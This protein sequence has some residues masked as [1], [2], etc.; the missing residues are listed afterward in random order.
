MRTI[1]SL[2]VVGLLGIVLFGSDLLFA[3]AVGGPN[4][5]A[6]ARLS[7]P[8]RG[9]YSV[10]PAQRWEEALVSGNGT[11]GVL[12]WGQPREERII[13]NHEALYEPLTNEPCQVPNIAEAFPKVRELVVQGKYK[14]AY[15]YSIKSAADKGYSGPQPTD[16]YHPAMAMLIRQPGQGQLDGYMRSV[17]FT[18]GEIT[19]AWSDANDLYTRRTFVS[20][21]DNVVVLLIESPSG[22]KINASITLA[23]QDTRSTDGQGGY[24]EP[25]IKS[26]PDWIGYR[27]KYTHTKRGYECLVRVIRKGGTAQAN[28]GAVQIQDAN[29][30]LLLTRIVPLEDFSASQLD[31]TQKELA[32]LPA[33]YQTLLKPHAKVHGDMFSRMSLDLSGGL[34]RRVSTEELLRM[35]KEDSPSTVLPAYLEK[36]FD[37]GRYVFISASGQRPPN[38]TGIWN[39]QWRPA[40]S[41]GFILDGDLN[42]QMAGANIGNMCEGTK[43]YTNLITALLPDWRT[44]AKNLFGCRGLVSGTQTD[45]RHGLQTQFSDTF[46][47]QFWTAG[48]E[49]LIAPMYEYYQVTGDREYLTKTLLPIMKEI[50]QFYSDFLTITTQEGQYMFAP[51]YSPENSPSNTHCPAAVNADMDLACAREVLTN[52]VTVCDALKIEQPN[53]AKWQAMLMK[54]PPYRID[55]DG[56]LKEWAWPWLEDNADHRHNSLFY[57]VW[58]G[59]EINP[60]D[61]P[62]MFNAAKIAARKRGRESDSGYGLADMA[63]IGARLKDADIVSKNLLFMLEGDYVLP[64][65]FTYGSPGQGYNADI[66]CSLPAIVIEMLVYSRPGVVELLPA[67][68]DSMRIGQIKGVL[69]RGQI[70]ITSLE[71]NLVRKHVAVTM[72]SKKDQ[73]ISLILRRGMAAIAGPGGS[74]FV[75]DNPQRAT[76]ELK[77]DKPQTISIILP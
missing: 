50:A 22:G 62:G 70:A 72:V 39:G 45:G 34:D 56:A 77:K 20:R 12:V 76:V 47:G 68:P 33:S 64:S 16:P 66:V 57:A 17:D 52:L 38:L 74:R 13:F 65:L 24:V 49:S 11:M 3:A 46:P 26:T 42:L 4:E 73:T 2:G 30:V 29:S 41:G 32:A 8:N 37:M 21:P 55:E 9:M 61:T 40:R 15:D 28:D 23:G 53:V 5:P 44:N 1:N 58:P 60:E 10:Q 19:V 35:Q 75:S 14:E 6:T 69:C 43:S 48:A 25:E 54:I 18:T 71:W 36:M 51:S 27:C 59:H 67:V 63:L 7:I 31:R